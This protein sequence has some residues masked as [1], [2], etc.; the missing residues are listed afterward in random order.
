MGDFLE[1]AAMNIDKAY[2]MVYEDMMRN[3]FDCFSG[4][5]D[6]VNISDKLMNGV[7]LVM[8]YIAIMAGSLDEY[9]EI[10]SANMRKS[11]ERAKC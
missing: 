2:E 7:D 4:T 3:G 6:A 9:N 5:Y 1:E 11:K 10:F 8:G